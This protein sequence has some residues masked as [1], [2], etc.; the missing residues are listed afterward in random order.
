MGPIVWRG[1]SEAEVEVHRIY[2]S[3]ASA[4]G[5]MV[6]QKTSQGWQIVSWIINWQS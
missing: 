1:A 3:M 5:L 4:G 6:L 2:C